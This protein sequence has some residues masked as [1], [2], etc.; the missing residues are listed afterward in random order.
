MHLEGFSKFAL[1]AYV[2]AVN[3]QK[4]VCEEASFALVAAT[5]SHAFTALRNP[6][7]KHP[8]FLGGAPED[9]NLH[10]IYRD[11]V[12][13]ERVSSLAGHPVNL[14]DEVVDTESNLNALVLKKNLYRLDLPFD[15]AEQH[16]DDLNKF[17]A[18]T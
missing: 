10:M 7:S 8:L 9:L 12:F 14:P 5:H 3:A 4:L 1:T 13:I 16:Q 2:S 18:R 17:L 11:R 6:T 15:V